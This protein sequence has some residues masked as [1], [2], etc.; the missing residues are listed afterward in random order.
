MTESSPH[1][2]PFLTA[3]W[4]DLIMLNFPIE[5]ELLEPLAPA[6]TIVDTYRGVAYISMVGFLF[7]KTKVL[8][9]PM[10]FHQSFEEVNLRFYVRHFTGTEWRRGVVF[11]KEIVP[12]FLVSNSARFFYNENY[13]TCAMRHRIEKREDTRL[14]EYMWHHGG[15]WHRVSAEAAG[16]AKPALDG[17]LEEFITD[18]QWGYTRQR[19][20]STLEYEVLHPK[21]DVASAKEAELKCDAVA[22]YGSRFSPALAQPSSSAFVIS[23]SAVSV[24]RGKV[25]S[26]AS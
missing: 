17:S 3:E 18:H 13:I 2:Q 20:G 14:L 7:R 21:W 24:Y 16:P 1:G 8:G 5:R 6:G 19:D 10:L 25:V 26:P 9:I 22:L 23:G 12:A 4:C 15:E 11:I